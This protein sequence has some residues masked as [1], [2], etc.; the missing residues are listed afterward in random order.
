MA[1]APGAYAQAGIGPG[2]K[3]TAPPCS[4]GVQ[5]GDETGVD[6]GGSCVLANV[7]DYCD[8]KDNNRNC[9]V[10][11]DCKPSGTVTIEKPIK[12]SPS[13]N[14]QAEPTC[15]DGFKNQDELWDDCGGVCVTN[16]TELCDGVD[17][18]R[19][20]VID[21]NDACIVKNEYYESIMSLPLSDQGQPL[22]PACD[23][24][25]QDGGESG[26]DCG[27]PCILPEV[28]ED[29]CDGVDNNKDCEVDAVRGVGIMCMKSINETSEPEAESY[30]IIPAKKVPS[31]PV[32]GYVEISDIS[33]ATD[34]EID[35]F[36][37]QNGGADFI[38]QMRKL[39]DDKGIYVPKEE[40]DAQFG[41]KYVRHY[42]KHQSE[43]AKFEGKEPAEEDFAE[44]LKQF[45]EEAYPK[46]VEQQQSQSF[47]SK[48]AGFFKRLFS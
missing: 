40:S 20:C 26:V 13:A 41:R 3:P 19:N 9:L 2:S 29:G 44:I 36:I 22:L 24:G 1:L 16:E 33:S 38:K 5:D 14:Q 12:G 32:A 43:F 11:E 35:A 7:V 46:P 23:N 4:N 18:N 34:E 42:F 30:P 39:A 25:I 8:G 10:D 21:E 17:N 27:G 45:S 6:C 48:V 37:E 15:H 47:F 28:V 31:E